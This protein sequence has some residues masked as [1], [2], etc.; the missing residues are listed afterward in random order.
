MDIKG[1]QELLLREF[2]AVRD[3]L[4][5]DELERIQALAREK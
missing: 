4:K 5:P 3:T 1:L 2:G